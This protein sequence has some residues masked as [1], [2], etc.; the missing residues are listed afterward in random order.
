MKNENN[1]QLDEKS[2]NYTLDQLQDSLMSMYDQFS[3]EEQHAFDLGE[4]YGLIRAAR[5]ENSGK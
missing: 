4:M 3:E 5:K 1:I 2:V